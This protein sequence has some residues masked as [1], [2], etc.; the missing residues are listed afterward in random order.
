VIEIIL[1]RPITPK[2]LPPLGGYNNARHTHA[3]KQYTHKSKQGWISD[4]T[5]YP[6]NILTEETIDV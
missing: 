2:K 6:F 1:T 4:G 5:I 3:A